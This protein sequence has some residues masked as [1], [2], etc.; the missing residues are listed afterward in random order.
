VIAALEAMRRQGRFVSL[1]LLYFP[2]VTDRPEEIEALAALI[3]R[4][5]VS[6]IQLRNLNIDPELYRGALPDGVFGPGLG[7][8][9]FMQ[10]LRA[11]APRLRFGY[12]NP[13]K[14]IYRTW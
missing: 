9:T 13:P 5:G 8:S 6:L 10:G 14:E 3:P 11:R 2:G 4:A 12:F 7:L 1:N